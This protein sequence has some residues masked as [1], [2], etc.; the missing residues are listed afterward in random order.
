MMTC[1]TGLGQSRSTAILV[2]T[3]QDQS[4]N[5]VILGPTNQKVFFFYAIAA[6]QKIFDILQISLFAANYKMLFRNFNTQKVSTQ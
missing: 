5:T 3:G 2:L 6:N 1:Y 4:C